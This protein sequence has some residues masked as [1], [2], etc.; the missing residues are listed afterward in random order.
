MTK[1][2]RPRFSAEQVQYLESIFPEYTSS[3]QSFSELQ[4]RAGQRSVLDFIKQDAKVERRYV[5]REILS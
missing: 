5:Q 4:H 1:A 2:N 3:G